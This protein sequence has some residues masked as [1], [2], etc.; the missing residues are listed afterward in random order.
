MEARWPDACPV[1]LF[2]LI[3]RAFPGFLFPARSTKNCKAC[4]PGWICTSVQPV[5][6]DL[7]SGRPL[8][9]Y[10]SRLQLRLAGEKS[11]LGVNL[12]CTQK[13]GHKIEGV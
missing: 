9:L 2:L 8:L 1:T 11:L 5:Q 13:V 10:A 12:N 6:A 3:C 4:L 7:L